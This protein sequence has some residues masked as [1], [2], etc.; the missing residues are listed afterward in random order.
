[1][2]TSSKVALAII[3]GLV[4]VVAGA[5]YINDKIEEDELRRARIGLQLKE[6]ED[7]QNDALMEESEK[8]IALTKGRQACYKQFIADDKKKSIYADTSVERMR[9]ICNR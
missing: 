7:R 3:L 8:H 6:S 2:K 4:V 9:A 1:M 5:V